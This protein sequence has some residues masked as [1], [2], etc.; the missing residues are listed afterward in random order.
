MTRGL[1]LI[2]V[3]V[4][5]VASGGQER[6]AYP[7]Q[8]EHKQPPKNFFCSNHPNTPKTHKCGC[9]IACVKNE[10]TGQV[11]EHED[12]KCTVYCWAKTHCACE[13]QCA[14]T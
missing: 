1:M 13:H 9:Q 6:E 11:E 10:E 3:F 4:A 5:A 7:G 12:P 8:R 2:V 14:S